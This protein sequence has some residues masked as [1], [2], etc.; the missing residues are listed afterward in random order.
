[1]VLYT[2]N[3]SYLGDR[4]ITGEG[5]PRQKVSKTPQQPTSWVCWCMLVILAT[6]E[7]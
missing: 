3:P 5:Q 6:Q 1:M 7:R 2:Y 4:R